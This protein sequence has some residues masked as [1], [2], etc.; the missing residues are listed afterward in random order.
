VEKELAKKPEFFFWKASGWWESL[1][2]RPVQPA[3]ARGEIN[4]KK[5]NREKRGCEEQ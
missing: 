2:K 1:E 3:D 5:K 4:T